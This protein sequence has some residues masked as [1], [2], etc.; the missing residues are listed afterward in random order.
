MFFWAAGCWR[1]ECITFLLHSEPHFTTSVP[2]ADSTLQ[3]HRR[4][5]GR[6]G[7][8]L[9]KPPTGPEQRVLWELWEPKQ[10]GLLMTTSK[11]ANVLMHYSGDFQRALQEPDQPELDFNRSWSTPKERSCQHPHWFPKSS[12]TGTLPLSQQRPTFQQQ[13]KWFRNGIVWRFCL[14]PLTP[15][16]SDAGRFYGARCLLPGY[17]GNPCP[18][19]APLTHL[20]SVPKVGSASPV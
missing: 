15:V 20:N 11:E 16:P 5:G 12:E 10:H 4:E 7:W 9:S 13:G 8:K 18:D 17:K 2:R 6:D 1:S 3:R 14:Q 19:P